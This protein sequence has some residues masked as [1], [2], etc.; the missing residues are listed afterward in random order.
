MKRLLYILLCLCFFFSISA[1]SRPVNKQNAVVF[2][3]SRLDPTFDDSAGVI[4]Q[5][6]RTIDNHADLNNLVDA[7][8]L[9]PEDPAL[10]LLFP[11]QTVLKAMEHIDNTL[12]IVL[13]KDCT[14]MRAIDLV[15]SCSCLAKTLQ[16]IT[17]A[18]Q[19]IISAE[20][21]F[22]HWDGHLVFT[23]DSILTEDL[24][25]QLG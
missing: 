2:Y 20:E 24:V 12:Q 15:I 22:T 23:A 8:L 10:T 5:E 7:Y 13:S 9:G 4:A 25:Q 16:S 17:N 3:Y 1:C 14:D 21:E 19:I 11:N 18:E 6:I